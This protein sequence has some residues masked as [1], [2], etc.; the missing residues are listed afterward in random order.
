MRPRTSAYKVFRYLREV[1]KARLD[2]IAKA[3]GMNKKNV[4]SALRTLMKSGH[5]ERIEKGVYVIKKE[6]W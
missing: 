6:V 2:E 4:Y 1:K 5:V 3:T